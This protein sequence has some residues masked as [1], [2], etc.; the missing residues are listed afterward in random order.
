MR[1]RNEATSIASYLLRAG[2]SVPRVRV[3]VVDAAGEQDTVL[4]VP[5]TGSASTPGSQRR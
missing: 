5:D 1:I 3:R 2:A 4:I